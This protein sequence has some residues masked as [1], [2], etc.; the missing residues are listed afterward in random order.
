MRQGSEVIVPQ[1]HTK[2]SLHDTP[3]A[4][5]HHS[6]FDLSPFSTASNLGYPI[7]SCWVMM[8]CHVAPGLRYG[9]SSIDLCY[10]LGLH[11][12]FEGV[13]LEATLFQLIV[14]PLVAPKS[15]CLLVSCRQFVPT[16]CPASELVCAAAPSCA[17]LSVHTDVCQMKAIDM[18]PVF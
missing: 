6:G 16:S 17:I 2:A 12:M 7:S 9:R 15:Y 14:S 8:G 5:F 18:A 10:P 13:S 3:M 4:H 1:E 11:L